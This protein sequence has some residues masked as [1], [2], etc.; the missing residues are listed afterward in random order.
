MSGIMTQSY[1]ACPHCTMP[2]R[3][4]VQR[5]DS[6]KLTITYCS[7]INCPYLRKEGKQYRRQRKSKV[8]GM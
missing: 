6:I 1:K 7:N 2:M 3:T 4:A 5:V 8:K